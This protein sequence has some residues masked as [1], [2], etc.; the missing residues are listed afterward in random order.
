[1]TFINLLTVVLV[2]IGLGLLFYTLF[3]LGY[4]ATLHPLSKYPGPLHLH[5][6]IWQN[7]LKYGP[8][9]RLG[10]NKLVFSSI[11]ALR[12]IYNNERLSKSRA[13]LVAMQAPGVHSIFDVIDRQLHRKKRKV[14]GQAL[15]QRAMRDFEPIIIEQTTVFLKRIYDASR[16]TPYRPIN[17]TPACRYLGA[18]IVSLLAFGQAL[19][20]QTSSENRFLVEGLGAGSFFQNMRIQYPKL[21]RLRL[22]SLLDLFAKI[23]GKRAKAKE[24][25]EKLITTRIAEGIEAKHDLYSIVASQID[26]EG[27]GNIRHS[28]FWTESLFFLPAGG[29]T[30]STCLATLFFYLSRN[31]VCYQKLSEEIRSTFTSGSEIRDGQQLRSCEYLRACIDEALRIAPP[32]PSVLWREEVLTATEKGDIVVDGHVIPRGTQVGV[33]I[34]SLH[35]NPDY[36]PDPFTYKPERWLA[37]TSEIQS[38]TMREAFNPFSLGPRACAGKAMAYM[39]IS[40]LIGRALWYFDFKAAQGAE[41]QLGAGKEGDKTG[42]GRTSEFQIYDVFS[43]THDG[44]NLLFSSRKETIGEILAGSAE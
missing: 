13:Y 39:E 43:S 17:M 30:T 44:P 2:Y 31:P 4:R 23:R 7:H 42:R 34:Y 3:L 35:H 11:T 29:D 15:T 14:I 40:V 24:L 41:G 5:L 16:V 6:A 26:T 1:M 33:S 25:I 21:A 20:T 8:V 12:D 32:V 22:S 9:I 27:N 38:S 19:N 18:D 36:F 28:E 10:P 37:D